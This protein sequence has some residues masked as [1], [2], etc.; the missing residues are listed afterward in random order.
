LVIPS[1]RAASSYHLLDLNFALLPAPFVFLLADFLDFIS[2]VDPFVFIDGS[3]YDEWKLRF[4]L[5][6][7]CDADHG[8][9][10]SNKPLD[11]EEIS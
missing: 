8:R 4:V 1:D 10:F 7:R 5:R 9:D 6:P 2:V 11:S 3:Q